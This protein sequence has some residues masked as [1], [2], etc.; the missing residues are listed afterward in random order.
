[1]QQ[2][3]RPPSPQPTGRVSIGAVGLLRLR[4]VVDTSPMAIVLTVADSHDTGSQVE[5]L[6]GVMRSDR[7]YLVTKPRHLA[8]P[9]FDGALE[10]SSAQQLSRGCHED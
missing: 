1:M 9:T 2:T 8:Q 5:S 6:P 3:P 7:F 10:P 4:I